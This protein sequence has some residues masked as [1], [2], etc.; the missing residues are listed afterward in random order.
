MNAKGLL[1]GLLTMTIAG[2][3]TAPKGHSVQ[4]DFLIDGKTTRQE[5]M[6]KLGEPSQKLDGERILTYRLGF[7]S[8]C[9][10]YTVVDRASERAV[11][12]PSTWAD[13]SRGSVTSWSKAKTSLV[14]LFDETKIL[15]RHSLVEVAR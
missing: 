14:L 15:R 13:P 2:C 12:W 6:A 7:D 8:Q 11:I 3:A 4:L 1:A 10:G 9:G 5:V